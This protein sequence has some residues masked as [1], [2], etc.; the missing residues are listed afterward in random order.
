MPEGTV[1]TRPRG[2]HG[3]WLTLPPGVDPEAL[4]HAAA[5]AGIAYA[6]GDV[7]YVDG[8]G[9]ESI[10]LAFAALTPNA[11]RDGVALLADL[12]RAHGAKRRRRS[13]S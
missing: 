8:R 2:G 1:W 7:F 11:I 9:S 5:L 4:A 12:I 3:V 6:P 10:H 13:T